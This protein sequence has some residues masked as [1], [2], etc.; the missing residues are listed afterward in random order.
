MAVGFHGADIGSG[1]GADGEA[2]AAA[3]CGQ[4]GD[5]GCHLRVGD[6]QRRRAAIGEGDAAKLAVRVQ[7]IQCGEHVGGGIGDREADNVAVGLQGSGSRDRRTGQGHAVAAA[8][9]AE[10]GGIGVELCVG[11]RKRRCGIGKTDRRDQ[12]VGVQR[13]ERRLDIAGRVGHCDAGDLGVAGQRGQ[14]GNRCADNGKAGHLAVAL[15]GGS[16]GDRHADN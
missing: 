12:V 10:H 14:I 3:E 6:G 4:R 9:F 5:V 16:I 2:V 13:I 11:H 15:H 1:H 7:R 8:D